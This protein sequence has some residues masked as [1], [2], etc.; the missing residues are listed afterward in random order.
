[1]E[2]DMGLSVSPWEGVIRHYR[3]FLPIPDK[4]PIVTLLEGNTPLLRARSLEKLIGGQAEVY[5][6]FEGANPTG[7]FKDRGM[8]VAVSKALGQGKR[9]GICASTGNTSSSAAAYCAVAGMK[10]AIVIPAGKIATGKLAQALA[11]GALVFPIRGDFDDA[12]NIVRSL[13]RE[14]SIALLNSLN[15]D[16]LEGQKTCAFEICDA[17][18]DAPDFHVLPVGNA[19]NITA[20]WIGYRQYYEAGR[21]SYLPVLV[22]VQAEGAA[23]LVHG[24][25]IQRPETIATAIRIGKPA[26]WRE[27]IAVRDESGGVIVAVPDTAIVDAYRLLA[28]KEGLF[29]EPASA[30]GVAG[31]LRLAEKGFFADRFESMRKE[32]RLT[33]DRP[34]IVCILTGHG[35]KDPQTAL[36]TFTLPEPLP[37]TPEAIRSL[38]REA[39]NSPSPF[40]P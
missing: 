33:R 24:R 25:P 4:T 32:K 17:L 6:K 1:M 39:I 29:V 7:S 34:I 11:H 31:L 37:P 27:A 28:Q 35:L 21:I 3:D 9:V 36:Q 23:P 18:K 12:L 30:A 8:T 2:S 20:H 19:G 40:C 10:C 13:S 26:R 5:L 16:R 15:P 38:L 22:G 14:L